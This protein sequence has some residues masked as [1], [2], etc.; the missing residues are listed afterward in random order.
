MRKL[1]NNIEFTIKYHGVHA[2]NAESLGEALIATSKLCREANRIVPA[3]KR[4]EMEVRVSPTKEGSI[5]IPFELSPQLTSAAVDMAPLVM[6]LVGKVIRFWQKR[7]GRPIEKEDIPDDE[8]RRLCNNRVH[9]ALNALLAPLRDQEI[10]EFTIHGKDNELFIKITKKEVDEGYFEINSLTAPDPIE[11]IDFPVTLIL[12]APV[13]E[14]GKKW[15]F[16]FDSD[17]HKEINALILDSNFN[18][19][20]FEDG[21]RF[22]FGDRFEGILRKRH[23]IIRGKMYTHYEILEVYEVIEADQLLD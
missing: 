10:A 8:V 11:D 14:K 19:R 2:M 12:K 1:E 23:K 15:K 17:T 16:V 20:V 7:K 21:E 22:G 4:T 5:E 6:L 3:R 13:F 18:D 9:T